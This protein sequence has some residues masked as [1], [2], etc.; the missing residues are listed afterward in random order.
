MRGQ[1][2][3]AMMV[4]GL[5][6]DGRSSSGLARFTHSFPHIHPPTGGQHSGTLEYQWSIVLLGACALIGICFVVAKAYFP[7]LVLDLLPHFL[8]HPLAHALQPHKRTGNS[9]RLTT[10]DVCLGPAWMAAPV[11]ICCFLPAVVVWYVRGRARG[12]KGGLDCRERNFVARTID[13]CRPV[14]ILARTSVIVGSSLEA[15]DSLTLL[16][17]SLPPSSLPPSLPPQPVSGADARAA[18]RASQCTQLSFRISRG[19]RRD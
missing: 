6:I 1:R 7:T 11:C 17:P 14:D 9:S 18:C 3:I 10:E 19:R 5:A 13:I 16:P 2:A 15:V 12:V 8:P 4:E